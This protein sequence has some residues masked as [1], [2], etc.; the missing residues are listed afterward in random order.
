[1]AR[2][3]ARVTAIGVAGTLAALLVAA[4]G[5]PSGEAQATPA[6]LAFPDTAPGASST[7]EVTITN[8]A[9]SGALTVESVGISGPNAALFADAFDDDGSVVLDPGE[10]TTVP[11]TY[12]PI[13]PGA[14]AASLR[15]SNSGAAA[16][17]VPLSGTSGTP[18]PGPAPLTPVPASVQ[19]PATPIGQAAHHDVVLRSDASAG[20]IDVESA[21]VS[22]PDA[23]MFSPDAGALPDD[24]EP[25]ASLTVPVTFAPTATGPRAAILTVVHSGSNTPL[26]VALGGDATASGPH[27]VLH[28]VD[29]GGPGVA[30]EPGAPAWAA[31]T[32]A[33]PSPYANVAQ[34]GNSVAAPWSTPVDTSDPSVPPG[35][36]MAIFQT[37]RFD[38][39]AAPA[40]T[41]S[42]PVPTG[43][44]VEVR[45]YLAELDSFSQAAGARVFDVAVDGRTAF[46]DVDTFARVGA[47]KGLVLSAATV[48]DGT[49]DVAFRAGVGNPAVKALEVVATGG[50]VPPVLAPSPSGVSF[51]P[52]PLRQTVTRDVVLTNAGTT[53]PLTVTSTA[54]S[55]PDAR[56]FADRFDDATDVTLDPGES[57]TITVAL[58][59]TA[60]GARSATL[61]VAHT[62]VGSPLA[63]PLSATVTAPTAPPNPAFGRS[64][65]AGAGVDNPTSLQFGPDG[66]LYVAQMD[67][68]IKVLTV[69]RTAP[70][71]YAV[72]ATETIT[73]VRSLPNHNDDGALNPAVTT[74]LVTGLLVTGT[75]Q[76]PQI[77]VVSSDPRIGAGTSGNDLNLDTNSGILS[78]LTRSGGGWQKVDLVRGLPR[79]EENHTG[80]GLNLDP[81]TN[82]LLLAYGGHTNKGAPSHN[83]ALLPEYALSAAILS[84]D[85]DAVGNTTYDLPTLDDEDRPG[86][87]DANDPFGGNDGKNQARLV[88]G[89]PVQVYAPGFR[90]PYDLV[91]TASGRL[92]TIDNGGNAGWGDVPQPDGPGGTCTNAP[93][94]PGTTDSDVLLRITGQGF[95][96]G[97]P[98]PTRGN[99]ANRFNASN[100]QSPVAAGHPVECDYRTEAE[101]GALASFGFSTNGLTEYTASTFGGAM[102]G[103]LL[104]A[105]HGDAIHRIRLTPDG[106][107]VASSTVLF[108]S[109]A[110]TPLDVT[111]VGDAGPFPGSI[112]V[113]DFQG[114]AIVVF[115]P[116]SA[117]CTGAN[118]PGL[119]ED[120]DGFDN[121]DE[122]ANGT[123]PCSS[124]DRPPDADGDHD[125]DL[126]DPDDDQDGLP[127]TSDPF[128]VDGANG[129]STPLPTT[130]TWDNDAPPA[131]GLLGLGFTGL[132]TDG[133]TNYLGM[134][135]ASG[136]TAGGAAGVVTVDAVPDGDA[137]GPA[138][139]QR[140]GFQHGIDVTPSSGP[141]VVHTRLP[142]PFTGLT[143]SGAQ[144]Y[145][146]FVGTGHQDAYVSLTVA[147][148][149]GAGGFAL[150]AEPAG[151]PTVVTVPGPVW[152][153]ADVVD[154]F[155]RVDPAAGTVQASASID[156]GAPVAIGGPVAVP[157]SWFDRAV[158]PAVGIIATS[159]GPAPPFPATWD[160]L[161]V[162]PAVPG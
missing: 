151:V 81:A 136:M 89:G 122:I 63:I 126:L 35:T 58:L 32:A 92:Y 38:G 132:M 135:D 91:R 28:R 5:V 152:P 72:T 42:F 106:T 119:D 31:D 2:R 156:G 82:T 121:A 64:L 128:A 159:S 17:T 13:A 133:V 69:A 109:A 161:E 98:N 18:A 87:A 55:G 22:G 39:P 144:S 103:D 157:T 143:P 70:Q 84:V 123:S 76:N 20:T 134:F 11:V 162:R 57:T 37:E 154:L 116:E 114:D 137:L 83:F 15:V 45:V 146:V 4:C 102:R 71:T 60:L 86:S 47:G 141:F 148:N 125:S 147:A 160:F 93:A 99:P 107:A 73:L 85:L 25:G 23:A 8:V 124:A 88:P 43:V 33:T 3:R 101:R 54:I 1:M 50:D 49:V 100:P 120:G 40:L 96:G 139:S 21:T 153:G 145:G 115:E 112:W 26:Q 78:R 53:G 12:S 113:A 94:E 34:S 67:G 95:Y 16:L 129:R 66:R 80:N 56:M 6:S 14:H 110:Q 24:L 140:Y 19:F 7:R 111:A 36:P 158:A 41:Y 30:G 9:A 46:R 10:S 68:T 150:V 142:A 74:R 52:A 130:L 79:S 77:Y 90:N 44:P 118:D 108:S 149:G 138:N 27:P 65:L 117:P 62:G 155:L 104:T 59:P 75:A 51:S 131:G 105:S 48:S 97:H 61:S 127:D 29:A